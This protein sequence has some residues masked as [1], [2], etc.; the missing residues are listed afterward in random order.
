VECGCPSAELAAGIAP[1]V[2]YSDLPQIDFGET[3]GLSIASRFGFRVQVVDKHTHPLVSRAVRIYRT[4]CLAGGLY[5]DSLSPRFDCI[6]WVNPLHDQ[7]W[8]AIEILVL[9]EDP[10]VLCQACSQHIRQNARHDRRAKHF[11]QSLEA[12]LGKVRVHVKEKI[13]YILHGHLEISE[14]Q[15]I[16]QLGQ[17]IE[18]CAL[19]NVSLYRHSVVTLSSPGYE[20]LPEKVVYPRSGGY[21]KSVPSNAVFGSGQANSLVLEEGHPN[22]ICFLVL[23]PFSSAEISLVRSVEIF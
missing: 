6:A 14:P 5:L 16:W 12:L 11:V 7:V 2:F 23:A 8:V 22:K 10:R 9:Y 19:H 13:I 4:P 21:V 3:H 18:F 15:L 20:V 17:L 1:E